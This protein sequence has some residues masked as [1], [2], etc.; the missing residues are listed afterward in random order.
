MPTGSG[1]SAGG[2]QPAGEQNDQ[3]M[4]CIGSMASPDELPDC[5]PSSATSSQSSVPTPAVRNTPGQ[6][7][8]P[9]WCLLYACA[10]SA[11]SATLQGQLP[12]GFVARADSAAAAAP[13]G[14]GPSRVGP[15][16]SQGVQPAAGA[17]GAAAAAASG[18]AGSAAGRP[19]PQEKRP[20]KKAGGIRSELVCTP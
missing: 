5:K 8:L 3:R 10:G 4:P 6:R 12:A 15:R 18:E 17:E 2:T 7:S 16:V 13:Q 9:Q 1:P 14:S 11:P 20:P 19:L